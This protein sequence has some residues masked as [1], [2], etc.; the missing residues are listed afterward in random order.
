MRTCR[1]FHLNKELV[2]FLKAVINVVPLFSKLMIFAFIIAYIFAMLGHLLFRSYVSEW[3]SPLLSMVVIQKL[4]LPVDLLITMES[5]MSQVHPAFIIFFF[6]NFLLSL[7]ICNLSLSIVI[8]W[9]SDSLNNFNALV[10]R[11]SAYDNVFKA[12]YSRVR[13]RDRDGLNY[14]V[15]KDYVM[16]KHDEQGDHRSKFIQG[17]DSF[18]IKDLK[19]CQKY[20]SID[21]LS[22]YHREKKKSKE[23][24]WEQTFVSKIKE[25]NHTTMA[26]N[27]KDL[28]YKEG[29]KADKCYILV[30]GIASCFVDDKKLNLKKYID[31]PAVSVLGGDTFFQSDGF[32]KETCIAAIDSV[33]CIVLTKAVIFEDLDPYQLGTIMK[34]SQKTVSAVQSKFTSS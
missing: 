28:I 2:I 26:L 7:I 27:M 23:L 17:E 10:E 13:G 29:E 20:S 12:I 1:L 15:L 19:Q 5:V 4:F 31:I 3:S 8:D 25:V 9:Y 30:S 32:Y 16:V 33:E 11:E 34:L 21:L 24:D 18:N 14:E 22:L 6:A